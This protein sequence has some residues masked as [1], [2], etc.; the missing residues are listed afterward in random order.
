MTDLSPRKIEIVSSPLLL[1]RIGATLLIV[2]VLE[3][4][5]DRLVPEILPEKSIFLQVFA[6]AFLL[7][8]FSA[9]FIW[10]LIVRPLRDSA[11]VEKAQAELRKSEARFRNLADNAPVGIF[12]TDSEGNC[13]FV[14]RKWCEIAGISPEQAAGQGWSGALHPEDMPLIEREWYSCVK[15]GR[16]FS[17]EYRFLTP[18]GRETWVFGNATS[19]VGDDGTV[20]GYMG[21]IIDVTQRRLAERDLFE[22]ED[23]FRTIFEQ[24]EDAIVLFAPLRCSIIDLNATT[25][26]LYGYS[27]SELIEIG[28]NLFRSRDEYLDFM[29]SVCMLSGQQTCQLKHIVNL[30]R[31]GSEIHVSVRAKVIRLRGED[32]IYCTL[33]DIT[34]RLR[35]EEEARSIQSQLIHANKMTSLG[36]LVAGIAHEVNNPNNY[37][38]A[39]ARMLENVW[40]DIAPLLRENSVNLDGFMFGGL[41]YGQLEVALPGMISAINEGA[42]RIRKIVGNLKNYSR[43]GPWVMEPVSLNQVVNA[44]LPLLRHHINKFTDS[45][46]TVLDES[47]PVIRGSSQQ[48]EQVV[49]NLVMNALQ[50]LTS[51][52]QR[53]TLKSSYDREN[54]MVNL[55]IA[56][57]G[58]GI[59]ESMLSRI[60]EPFFTTRLDS[61]GTGLGLSITRS[62]TQAHHGTLDIVSREGAGTIVTVSIPVEQD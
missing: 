47:V 46:E 6:D 5:V 31:D 26:K 56:D 54:A 58:V 9:P 7:A 48:L 12:E 50:S 27:K 32:V 57:E 33:R 29:H 51:R 39:N 13:I 59:P 43:Q 22:S 15:E 25:E 44:A 38:M 41:P 55:S 62:I 14:N 17:L 19:L 23:L 3:L 11:V 28:F 8:V 53:V 36:L 4:T 24:S 10:W 60:T 49:I 21:I 2:F 1:A 40:K 18:E 52:S 61:G 42:D 35:M 34:Q 45:F 20:N 16:I 30:R 37:I